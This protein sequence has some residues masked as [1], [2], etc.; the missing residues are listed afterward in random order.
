MDSFAENQMGR[1]D[2]A[3]PSLIR[4]PERGSRSARNS[5]E[6]GEELR[7]S[8]QPDSSDHAEPVDVPMMSVEESS[9]IATRW[10]RKQSTFMPV[11]D[12]F[13]EPDTSVPFVQQLA[14][15]YC[16]SR[17]LGGLVKRTLVGFF[18]ILEWLPKM[19]KEKLIKDV[20]AGFTVAVMLIPQSMSYAKIAGLQ[21][22]YGLYTSVLPLIVYAFMGSSRQLGVGPVAMVSLLVEVG[23]QGALNEEE[24]PAYFAQNFTSPNVLAPG[25][26][27]QYTL[28][29]DAYA[30]LAFLTSMLVG[31]F[32]VAAGALR[33]G[34][35]VSFLAH[36]V[37][38]GFTSAAAI[39]IGLSQLQYFLGFR[40]DKSQFI[41]V[42]LI[43]VFENLGRT[44][45]QQLLFG[46][47]WWFMLSASRR[48]SIH[49]KTKKHFSWLKPTA[50]LI[51]CTIA[52]LMGS[53]MRYFN[54]CGLFTNVCDE[55]IG[56]PLVVGYIP[57][58]VSEMISVHLLDLN[59]MSRV[60]STAISCSIIGYMVRR[61]RLT[62]APPHTH[63]HT[64]T[65]PP[66]SSLSEWRVCL[67]P[68]LCAGVHCDRQVAR[69]KTQV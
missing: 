2:V 9:L 13:A 51:T 5:K 14:R 17:Q 10:N 55:S 34:F 62:H 27:Q 7:P 37:I 40:I 22:K 52:I 3:S 8:A 20:I 48:L 24:C 61:A 6:G 29:P 59:K 50:P 68:Y 49:P 28:C 44:S 56:T 1:D 4:P 39:I 35:L 60:V 47:A 46:L 36:P 19:D 26:E 41:H 54:G 69:R 64:H 42:T 30:Q 12:P 21:Y 66:S 15:E 38:S 23:L 11:G 32:Q 16:T 33:L 67:P 43:Y 63:T 45:W 65:R 57:P 58:G 18:P 31:I 25:G 53:Q